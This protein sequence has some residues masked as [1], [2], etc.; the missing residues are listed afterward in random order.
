[1]AE[2]VTRSMS[3]VKMRRSQLI[4]DVT[5]NRETH[6]QAYEKALA[7]YRKAAV[8]VL[9][10]AADNIKQQIKDLNAGKRD[11]IG[12]VST[13]LK[14]PEEHLETY[15]RVL[16]MLARSVDEF[17]VLP[18]SQFAQLVMDKWSWSGDFFKITSAY[19]A[20][21]PQG[22]QGEIGAQGAFSFA[23]DWDLSQES[24]TQLLS[25]LK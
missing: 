18:E 4:E 13:W 10:A 3:E 23:P 21:G 1:M 11:T 8:L 12:N 6:K 24:L 17:L 14:Q 5:K 22:C 7:V 25:D 2:E 9:V 16:A 20:Q 15:D 19:G